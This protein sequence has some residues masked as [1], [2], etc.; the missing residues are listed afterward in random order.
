MTILTLFA[1]TLLEYAWGQEPKATGTEGA[2]GE[3]GATKFSMEAFIENFARARNNR[4]KAVALADTHGVACARGVAAVHASGTRVAL[5]IPAFIMDE[6]GARGRVHDPTF[7]FGRDTCRVAITISKFARLEGGDSEIPLYEPDPK[8]DIAARLALEGRRRARESEN[9]RT[10]GRRSPQSDPNVSVEG[11][12]IRLNNSIDPE[13]VGFVDLPVAFASPA[14]VLNF[15][16]MA[17][18]GPKNFTLLVGNAPEDLSIESR[19]NV[20]TKAYE[21][22]VINK[23]ARVRFSIRKDVRVGDSWIAEFSE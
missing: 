10:E 2:V 14:P 13:R 15:S 6:L 18:F 21:V 12:R 17:W 19:R 5:V 16:G 11:N 9:S 20:A 23:D 8:T 1:G 4:L 22:D 7:T 3:A